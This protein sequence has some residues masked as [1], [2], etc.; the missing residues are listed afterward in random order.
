MTN[1]NVLQLELAAL[2]ERVNSAMAVTEDS[3]TLT[4]DELKQLINK[5]REQACEHMNNEYESAID[6]INLDDYADLE[7]SGR[8]IEVNFDES[9]LKRDLQDNI[10]NKDEVDDTELDTLLNEVKEA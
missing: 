5:V 4:R 2:T 3:I 1:L 10:E 6:G 8:K 9:Q 7:L